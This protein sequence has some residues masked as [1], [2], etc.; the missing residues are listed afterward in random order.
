MADA[1]GGPDWP[2]QYALL[3]SGSTGKG[4]LTPPMALKKFQA[5]VT[6]DSRGS[7]ELVFATAIIDQEG[8]LQ[9]LRTIR[10]SGTRSQSA[11]S[12]LEKWEFAPAQLE[13]KPVSTRVLIGVM[14][15]SAEKLALQ[16]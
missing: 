5:R 6:T 9:G 14:V 4:L 7:S 3:A 1:G 15:V 11:L 8:K 16:N 10:N 13:G 2:M 12:A